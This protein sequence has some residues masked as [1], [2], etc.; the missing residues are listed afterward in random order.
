MDEYMKQIL[1]LS[2]QAI[3]NGLIIQYNALTA[4]NLTTVNLPISFTTINYAIV[5]CLVSYHDSEGG[6]AFTTLGQRD[7]D[8]KTTSSVT[9]LSTTTRQRQFIAMGY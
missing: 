6:A 5:T 4:K 8:H 3:N 2:V 7:V 9:Y 1:P